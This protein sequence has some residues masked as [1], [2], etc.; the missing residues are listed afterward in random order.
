MICS[1]QLIKRCASVIFA[2]SAKAA[3]KVGI[4]I[5]IFEIIISTLLGLVIALNLAFFLWY[6]KKTT[7]RQQNDAQMINQLESSKQTLL[8]ELSH[9]QAKLESLEQSYIKRLQ[10][11]QQNCEI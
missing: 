11:M 3:G 9:S 7:F 5:V 8:I 2:L 1:K 10:D 4:F 6:V